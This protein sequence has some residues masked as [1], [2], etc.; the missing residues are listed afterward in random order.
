MA[1][2][3]SYWHGGVRIRKQT[4]ATASE[5][6]IIAMLQRLGSQ[7]I[8]RASTAEPFK[9]EYT[10]VRSNRNGTKFWTTGKDH[11]YTAE[12]VSKFIQDKPPG[13]RD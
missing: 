9:P 13:R 3:I 7:H 8:E 5:E 10:E 4:V 1:W 6:E 2:R 12:R 11:H